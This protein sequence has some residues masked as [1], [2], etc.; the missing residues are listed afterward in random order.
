MG[1]GVRRMNLATDGHVA[2]VVKFLATDGHIATVTKFL[3]TDGQIATVVQTLLKA[4]LGARKKW[5]IGAILAT[6]GL[7]ATVVK[8]G[9]GASLLKADL[10]LLEA[11][12]G[13]CKKWGIGARGGNHL[14]AFICLFAFIY[15]HA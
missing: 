11:D 7:T 8:M 14:L 15:L 12:L 4:D 2:T 9:L 3:A 10:T 5:G 13:A 1:L 6:D